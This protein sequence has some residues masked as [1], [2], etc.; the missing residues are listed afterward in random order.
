[1]SYKGMK[2]N[3]KTSRIIVWKVVQEVEDEEFISIRDKE[4]LL[5]RTKN[6][7]LN[8]TA[9]E[10]SEKIFAQPFW[11]LW[12]GHLDANVKKLQK[13]IENKNKIRH[14]SP[15]TQ[16]TK[17]EFISFDALMIGS[18]VFA[19]SGQ[20]L[21]NTSKKKTRQEKIVIKCRFW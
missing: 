12:P 17:S 3:A 15:M 7:P 4:S 20:N 6:C 21:W 14:V 9:S 5:F 2:L 19:Q 8:D 10:I 16:V 11:T 1:M 18:T 13:V